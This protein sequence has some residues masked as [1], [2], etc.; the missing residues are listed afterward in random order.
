MRRSSQLPRGLDRGRDVGGGIDMSPANAT[1]CRFRESD[2]ERNTN[3]RKMGPAPSAPADQSGLSSGE[4]GYVPSTL[5][6]LLRSMVRFVSGNTRVSGC[7]ARVRS[8]NGC[9]STNRL[10]SRARAAAGSA[11]SASSWRRSRS[12][13]SAARR[14]RPARSRSRRCDSARSRSRCSRSRRSRARSAYDDE[15]DDEPY[16]EEEPHDD[17]EEEEDEDEDEDELPNPREP[18][19][20]LP[21]NCACSGALIESSTSTARARIDPRLPRRR[22]AVGLR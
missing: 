6:G 19:K 2:N 10:P 15:E 17:D 20:L 16:D 11:R 3:S 8:I 22:V 12:R 18:P 21:E 14:S 7:A 1:R 9:T 5:G 4:P 13:A